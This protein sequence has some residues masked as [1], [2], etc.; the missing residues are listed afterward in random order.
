MQ[1]ECLKPDNITVVCV[2]KACGIT[3]DLAQGYAQHGLVQEAL[4]LFQ[5]MQQEGQE[6][7]DVTWNLVIAG[8]VQNGNDLE[9]IRLFQ[10]LQLKSREPDNFTF[11]S[12]LK[13]CANTGALVQGRLFHSLS[14]ES[15]FASDILVVNSIIDMYAKCGSLDSARTVFDMFSDRSAVTW[16]AMIAG[17]AQHGQNHEAFRL[18]KEMEQEGSKPDN[19]TW[20]SLIAGY[21]QYGH[22]KEGLQV[23]D[24]MLLNGMQPDSVTFVSILKACSIIGALDLGKLIHS[25]ITASGFQLNI[26]VGNSLI[27]LY[28][29]WG[30]HQE[31]CYVFK[32]L[33][34][35]NMVTWN[36]M[37]TGYAFC[38]DYR[39]S[40]QYLEDMQ[41]EGLTPDCTTFS[42]IL[43]ACCHTG[44]VDEGLQWFKAMRKTYRM[45][46]GF[47]HY[48]CLVDLLGR[49]GH[50]IEAE[51]VLKTMPF[52][53]NI[54]GWMTLLSNSKSYASVDTA[55][56]CF[57]H[58]TKL[59]DRYGSGYVLMS[60]IYAAV[61]MWEDAGKVQGLRK[62]TMA[63]KMPGKAFIEVDN[64][65]H[66]VIAGDKSYVSSVA[67]SA[68]LRRLNIQSKKEGYV[69][70]LGLF[71][72]EEEK[73]LAC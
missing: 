41:R 21:I 36:T 40:L 67:I 61:D 56:R 39:L 46:P 27:D 43:S 35:Q 45:I 62:S 52:G 55:K 57:G 51:E 30:S 15:G 38:A 58:V 63:W 54:V 59:D 34:N 60:S 44:S 50:L 66:V 8:C 68:K 23:F 32:M 53:S 11:V 71:L 19:A 70:V 14:I 18:F 24:E 13:S 29:R 10:Q 1:Q 3:T 2:L 22:G 31:A 37:V 5:Q 17:Y 73:L 42:S 25:C 7:D 9:A 26:A 12:I 20:N 69:P 4:Q 28:A 16:N 64:I 33:P 72:P 65:L 6:P 48:N 47:E 49:A